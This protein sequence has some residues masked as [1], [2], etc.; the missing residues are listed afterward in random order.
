MDATSP[1]EAEQ[2]SATEVLS[3]SFPLSLAKGYYRNVGDYCAKPVS[4]SAGWGS[5]LKKF[6][7]SIWDERDSFQSVDVSKLP[8]LI[9]GYL[10]PVF[11][12][13]DLRQKAALPRLTCAYL[14]QIE[15]IIAEHLQD[16]DLSPAMIA[17][18]LGVSVSYVYHLTRSTGKTVG[19][20]LMEQRLE[21]CRVDLAD[22]ATPSRPITDIAFSW[23]FQELSHFSRRFS[24][25]YGKSPSQ[26]R[27]DILRSLVGE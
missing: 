4:T 9:A 24:E 27:K 10:D 14:E 3:V 21:R 2:L 6:I 5:L 8:A 25:K 20:M 15:Q 16:P 11:I 19:R 13:G 17:K 18:E 7:L 26:Y 22:P 23:G 12:S 1:I